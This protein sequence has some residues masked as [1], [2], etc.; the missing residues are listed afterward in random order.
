VA[1]SSSTDGVAQVY[2]LREHRLKVRQ[3]FA[4]DEHFQTIK[5]K[6]H[7]VFND[8]LRTLT[9]RSAHYLPGDAHC[10]ISAA[11]VITLLWDGSRFIKKTVWVE[12]SE[13]GAESKKKF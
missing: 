4:W 10:C 3:Q 9:V 11:D 8:K 12:L 1:G 2:E 5:K 7:V 13:Y 6:K